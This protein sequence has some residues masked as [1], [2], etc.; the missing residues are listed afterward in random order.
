M[1]FIISW[2]QT[3]VKTLYSPAGAQF[4]GSIYI[5]YYDCDF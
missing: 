1:L 3:E 5:Q 2:I 4:N